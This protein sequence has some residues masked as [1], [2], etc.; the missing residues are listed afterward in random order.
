MNLFG[1]NE[2]TTKTSDFQQ[3]ADYFVQRLDSIFHGVIRKPLL[4]YNSK[5]NP[6]YMLCFACGNKNGS[7]VALRI[8]KNI[9][10]G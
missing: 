6:L 8:A 9:L 2:V 3:I 1:E 10:N 5:N 4:L 7:K